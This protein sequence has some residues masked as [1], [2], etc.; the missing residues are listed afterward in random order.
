MTHNDSRSGGIDPVLFSP[1]SEI[2]WPDDAVVVADDALPPEIY[3][4]FEAPVLTTAG[5]ELKT[6]ERIE[7]L[8]MEILERRSTRP[9]T[10][11]AVGGGSVGDAVGFLASILWR[12]VDLWH[13]PTTL[14]A[15]V[16]S[17][18]GGKTAVNLGPFKNQLGTFHSAERVC[19]A[20]ELIETLPIEQREQG[21]AELIKAMWLDESVESQT[22]TSSASSEVIASAPYAVIASDLS[23]M[24]KRAI[25]VKY[26]IVKADPHEKREIRTLLNLGHTVA[27]ALELHLGIAH[28]HAVAWGLAAMLEVSST[29]A[30]LDTAVARELFADIYPLLNPIHDDALS[31]SGQLCELMEKDKKRRHGEL[32][33]VVLDA[34]GSARVIT[35]TPSDWYQGLES[36]W[37]R[38]RTSEVAVTLEADYSARLTLESSKSEMNRALVIAHFR[39]GASVH[40]TS[41]AAD[42][43]Y[44]RQALDGLNQADEHERVQV[45]AGSGGTTF[46][47][48]LAVAAARPGTTVISISERLSERPHTPLIE[49]L[50]RAGA[51]I[52]QGEDPCH[53]HV[54][55]WTRLP[56]SISVD[57]SV[58][59]QFASAIALLSASL[60]ANDSLTLEV[61]GELASASYFNLTLEMLKRVGIEIESPSER[62]WKLT[63]RLN[64]PASIQCQVDASS[65]AVWTC[66]ADLGVN[67]EP[68]A[69]ASALAHQPDSRLPDILAKLNQGAS[70]VDISECPDLVPVIST[71]AVV[72]RKR[73][74]LRGAAHLQH[75]ESNRIEDLCGELR[76]VGIDA[77][78][79][80]DGIV[81]DATLLKTLPDK[82]RWQTH[83]DHRL[84][85]A[86]LLLACEPSRPEV[87]IVDPWVVRKSYPRFYHDA[88]VCGFS[89]RPVRA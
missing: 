7:S 47:F 48:L 45:H 8:A 10:V 78:S 62:V 83:D 36:A 34:P 84:A 32:R 1:L 37:T 43:E 59:S 71:W 88:R 63:S 65:A 3:A 4:H 87:T 80:P 38:W 75:K 40:G 6:L 14:L 52:T 76:K 44:L 58:S 72:A 53:I 21:L 27:H 69:D 23:R 31:D 42:V 28:G 79:L 86:A 46:R 16:D 66:A 57:A 5:E 41:S 22:G 61:V 24:L 15:M 18:H 39:S 77:E 2:D 25:E 60:K 54:R 67:V 17:A 68:D 26:R 85:F 33:S 13:V 56:K 20:V 55:G 19:I 74:E 9:M 12:G 51:T 82:I 35:L 64:A 89:V 73:V 30:R 11:V 81:I 29:H 70:T 49:S 50:E